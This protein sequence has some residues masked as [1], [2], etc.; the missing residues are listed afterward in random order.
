MIDAGMA[1][2]EDLV[3]ECL[4]EHTFF[5]IDFIAPYGEDNTEVRVAGESFICA[6]PYDYVYFRIKQRQLCT[7]N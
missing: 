3:P 7:R 4:I 1:N 5:N 6:E 2:E